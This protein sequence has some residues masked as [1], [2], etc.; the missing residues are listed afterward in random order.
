MTKTEIIHSA[1][2]LCSVGCGVLIT[3]KDGKPDEITGDPESPPN[4]GGLCKIGLAS[5]EYLNHPD[6]LK[7]PL[8]RVARKSG[9][10]ILIS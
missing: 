3:L 8:K 7:H 6:R 4:R 1:C 5:L 2:G 9:D 10:T